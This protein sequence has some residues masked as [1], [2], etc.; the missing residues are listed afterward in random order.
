MTV[1]YSVGLDIPGNAAEYVPFGSDRSLFDADVV[2]FRPTFESYNSGETYLGRPVIS[3]GDS[4]QMLQ[5]CDH[6][7]SELAAA[8]DGGKV[9]FVMLYKPV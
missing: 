8:V 7:R 9:V 5:D 4:S 2:I 6:W 1:V 3:E